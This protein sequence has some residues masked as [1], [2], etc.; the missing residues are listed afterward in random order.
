VHAALH[1]AS[2]A[3]RSLRKG[4]DVDSAAGAAPH[5]R[6]LTGSDGVAIYD[7]DTALL[8]FEP[9]GDSLWTPAT[10]DICHRTARD[11]IAG[12]RRVLARNQS[13]AVVAQPILDND[14]MVIGVLIVVNTDE[15]SPGMLCA[16]AEVLT[17]VVPF[18]ALQP[19]GG[20]RGA[21]RHGRPPNRF[22]RNRR[23]Q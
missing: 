23:P 4:L 19:P 20:E 8:A 14:G 22:D 21:A 18:L 10:L 3:A 1:T 15:P 6:G 11:A 16:I 17:V 12:Q 7:G 13:P 9:P 5:L 2:L